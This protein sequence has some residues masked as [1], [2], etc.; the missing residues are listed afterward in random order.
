MKAIVC[1][2]YGSPDVLELKEVEK[3]TPKDN[4]V[5]IRVYVASATAADC[6]MR[7]GTPFYGRLFLGLKR[8]KNPITGTGFAGTIEA[9]GKEVKL[10]KE[11][12]SVFGETGIG[13][14]T[15]AE[16]VCLPEDGVLATLPYN[17]TYEEAAPL[18]DGALT[19]WSFLK[20]I[21]QIQCG[22]R[23]LINGASGSLGSAAV[24]I[25]KYFGAE[26]TGVCS[27]TNLEMVKSLGADKV[28]DYT[29]EDF[30]KTGQTYDIIFDTVGKSSF[31]RCKGSLR[32]N[33]V[34]LSPVLSL[35]L[36][37]EMIWTSKV[38]SKKAKFSATGLRPVSEL[39]VLLNELKECIEAGKIKSI[40][41]RS[42]PLK[43]TAEAHRY[44]ETGHKKGNV[45]ITIAP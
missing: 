10:F 14:S 44:I 1:T 8:P 33:G 32:E 26:V 29:K 38:G 5:L 11:G 3:P 30:T 25:A 40:V 36:L 17:M 18:C 13:F 39:R 41:D 15:N 9:V 34:Y 24:Q 12:D 21:G 7:Q 42:Y 19:S 35:P 27:T 37:F 22:Q 2:K 28:I 6:M 16:Y 20:D 43:Q 31:S 4:E 45:V 23:V